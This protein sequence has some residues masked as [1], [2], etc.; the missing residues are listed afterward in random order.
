MKTELLDTTEAI[1]VESDSI[2]GVTVFPRRHPGRPPQKCCRKT[3]PGYVQI[4]TG[5]DGSN[6]IIGERYGWVTHITHQPKLERPQHIKEDDVHVFLL[7]PNDVV[8]R[9]IVAISEMQTY[10]MDQPQQG[11]WQLVE[12]HRPGH[13]GSMILPRLL[14]S[15]SP[16][17]PTWH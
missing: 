5:H 14:V 2:A 10:E 4:V 17:K 11:V 3:T 1:A 16:M 9:V 6:Q 8:V 7:P 13:S 15:L 12:F